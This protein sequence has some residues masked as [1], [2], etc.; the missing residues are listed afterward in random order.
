TR[1][2]PE[3]ADS[4]L[5]GKEFL[6]LVQHAFHRGFA[7]GVVRPPGE[8]KPRLVGLVV[9]G[10]G[11][12]EVRRIVGRLIDAGNAPSTKAE[13]GPK[14]GDR[15]VIAAAAPRGQGFAW[16]TE[17]DA[18]A[19]SLISPAGADA[20][21]AALDGKVPDA[22]GSPARAALAKVEVGFEPVGL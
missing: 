22:A 19:L 17:G 1:A 6:T 13:A 20:M 9:R 16:W 2:L 15:T 8:A 10:A 5:S 21:I 18:L 14:P 3:G 7:V 11:K 12:G 4:K